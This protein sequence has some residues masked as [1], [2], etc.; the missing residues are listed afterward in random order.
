MKASIVFFPNVAKKNRK[1]GKVPLYMRI[2]YKAA[3]SE[4]RLNATIT[5]NELPL[6]DPRT[7]RLMERNSCINHQLNRLDQKFNEFLILNTNN[8]SIYTASGM[9]DYV[10]G[11]NKKQLLT[12]T[13]F[14]DD[15]FQNA[16][17]N[18]VSR[19]AGT[20]KNY[21]RS[22]NHLH[23]FLTYKNKKSILLE[24]LNYEIASDFKNY[25]VNSNPQLKRVGMTE[26][27]AAGIIKKFRTIF[28]EAV[29]QDLMKKNP[30]KTVKI[31]TKSP[32]R[33]R[34]TIDQVAKIYNLNLQ[35]FPYQELYRD[36]F[37][38]SVYTGL[39]YHD[40]I[41]LTWANLELKKDGSYKLTLNRQKTDVITECFLTKQAVVIATKYQNSVAKETGNSVLP[42]RSNKEINLQ[43]KLIAQMAGITIRLSTHIA[44]HTF[45]QLLAEAGVTDFG[46][47]KRMMGQSRNGDVYEVYYSVTERGLIDAKNKIQNLL[48]TNLL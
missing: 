37:L 13:K 15:Y 45:R 35:L 24:E 18:N 20:V 4:S 40:A 43:L 9:K 47:I 34:L 36:I 26:V 7:M 5:E 3:K 23:A 46:V 31:K 14:V 1:T 39:A 22:I 28:T 30:F 41:S 33:E 44:R 12:V 8:L 6:W 2:C 19:T 11:I 29:E 48:N 25:L 32:R 17:A 38:F 27:S 10:L 21:R 42:Y 16:I